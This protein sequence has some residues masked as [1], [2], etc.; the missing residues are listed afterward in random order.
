MMSQTGINHVIFYVPLLP[1]GNLLLVERN[2]G[3]VYIVR[4]DELLTDRS[5]T[6][7]EARAAISAFKKLKDISAVK[8]FPPIEA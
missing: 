7:D 2:D 4:N 1:S 8:R 3:R 5:W 6:R